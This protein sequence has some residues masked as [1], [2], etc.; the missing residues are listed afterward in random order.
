MVVADKLLAD[1]LALPLDDRIRIYERLI[2]S[3]V[4]PDDFVL[5]DAQKKLLD[6][7]IR[8]MEENPDDHVSGEEVIAK[9]RAAE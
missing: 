3:I 7:R 9:L 4:P 5:T 6:E 2:E 1:I 8:D